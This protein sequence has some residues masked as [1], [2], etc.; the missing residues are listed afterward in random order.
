MRASV[1]VCVGGDTSTSNKSVYKQ[2]TGAQIVSL[3]DTRNS[4]DAEIEKYKKYLNKAKKI[5][6]SF[7]G[8]KSQTADDNMEV[9]LVV[10]SIL[11]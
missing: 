4:K 6:E 9:S 10:R 5:I 7:G 2:T 11:W 8:N 3:E 1:C